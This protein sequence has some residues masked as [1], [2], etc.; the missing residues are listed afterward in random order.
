MSEYLAIAD[1]DVSLNQAATFTASIPCRN[2]LVFHEDGSGIF[3]LR[4][5]VRSPYIPFA[6][7]RV[8]FNGN[9]YLPEDGT[10]GPIA[11][12]LAVNGEPRTG[13]VAIVTPAAIEEPFN[14][15]SVASI[16]V[17]RGCDLTVSLRHVAP[18]AAFTATPA[19]VISI[20]NGNLIIDRVA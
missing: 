9:L 10:P 13:S 4:G 7:Y 20:A 17:P 16:L 5:I 18:P 19:P 8:V 1:Q 12:A 6:R 2:G 15:T 3:L 11:V 14:V